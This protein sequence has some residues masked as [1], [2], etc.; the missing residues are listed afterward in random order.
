MSYRGG[1]TTEQRGR[2][3]AALKT[4]QGS[5]TH[6]IPQSLDQEPSRSAP[7]DGASGW[8]NLVNC[9][10][11][12]VMAVRSGSDGLCLLKSTG[13]IERSLSLGRRAGRWR[14][15]LV[16]KGMATKATMGCE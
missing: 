2:S 14:F 13:R 1:D 3:R 4:A 6:L 12:N 15:V 5:A 10:R 11:G 8:T 16:A 7:H 9:R